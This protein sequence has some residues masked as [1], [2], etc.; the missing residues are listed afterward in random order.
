MIQHQIMIAMRLVLIFLSLECLYT[1]Q[2]HNALC[3]LSTYSILPLLT[4]HHLYIISAGKSQECRRNSRVR[5]PNRP[6]RG[7][8]RLRPKQSL[9][10]RNRRI[11]RMRS[12]KITINMSW[13]KSRGR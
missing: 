3:D 6:Q 1:T 4:G 11:W 13:R 10:H 9:M 2:C 7:P 8:G 12:G 5:I